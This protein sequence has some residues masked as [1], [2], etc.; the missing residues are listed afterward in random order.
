MVQAVAEKT[1]KWTH[2]AGLALGA[3]GGP[4]IFL[5][6][7]LDS[8]VLS[9][10]VLTDL[11]VMQQAAA[12]P[13]RMPYLALMATAGSLAGSA[14]LYVLAKKGGEAMFYKSAGRRAQQIRRWVGKHPVLSVAVPSLLPPPLP[15]KVFVIGA[16][17]FQMPWWMFATALVAGRGVRYLAEG[18]FAVRYGSAAVHLLLA[19]KLEFIV[20]GPGVAL[21]GYLVGR[22]FMKTAE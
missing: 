4:G 6:A 10:P 11:L 17:V 15:F 8:S 7:F 5:L 2:R 18:I 16:G 3:L 13:A 9:F 19:H 21:V 22:L 1:M 14:L 20:V 12:R